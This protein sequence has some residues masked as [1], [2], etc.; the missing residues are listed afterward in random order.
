MI[1]YPHHEE[2]VKPAITMPRAN[3]WDF[4]SRCRVDQII[5]ED[6]IVQPVE[7]LERPD[8]TVKADV[9]VDSMLG[10]NQAGL[11]LNLEKESGKY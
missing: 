4:G 3:V 7:N 5:A 1:C 6:Y 10:L 9:G 2:V 8:R 11:L